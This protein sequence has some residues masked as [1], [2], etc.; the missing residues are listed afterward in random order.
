MIAKVRQRWREARLCVLLDALEAGREQDLPAADMGGPSTSFLE[1]STSI[2]LKR[3]I[4][5]QLPCGLH[6]CM[7]IGFERSPS[8]KKLTELRVGDQCGRVPRAAATFD[9]RNGPA[10]HCFD[11]RDDIAYRLSATSA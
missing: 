2:R 11:R 3:P 6:D 10:A 7:Q 9:D 5:M 1:G 4:L 8:Q